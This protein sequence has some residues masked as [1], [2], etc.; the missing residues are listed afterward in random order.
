MIDDAHVYAMDCEAVRLW[1]EDMEKRSG[2]EE[3]ADATSEAFSFFMRVLGNAVEGRPPLIEMGY[4]TWIMASRYAP[5]VCPHSTR[6]DMM[7]MRKLA[8]ECNGHLSLGYL[9]EELARDV[10]EFVIGRA[11]TA[12]QMAKRVTILAFGIN[13][14]PAVRCALPSMESI[15]ILWGLSAENKRSA[16]SAAAKKIL[17]E[18]KEK[19]E[20]RDAHHRN[21]ITELW[22]AKKA[23]TRA[24]YEEAQMGNSNRRRG[25]GETGRHGD[26]DEG[27]REVR[28]EVAQLRHGIPVRRE[29]AAMSAEQLKRHLA[30]LREEAEARRLGD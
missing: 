20:R 15:G 27:K 22:Y 4:R 11:A 23:V 9:R 30:R 7:M 21:V 14:S 18:A 1:R 26:E 24:K 16:V 3:E 12:V 28:R 13:T 10:F 29:F 17:R 5:A 2:G 8:A 25:D 19:T 6:A